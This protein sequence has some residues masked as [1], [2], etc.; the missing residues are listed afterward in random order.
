MERGRETPT[1]LV[2]RDTMLLMRRTGKQVET[3]QG[4]WKQGSVKN[5][6]DGKKRRGESRERGRELGGKNRVS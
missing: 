2:V 5:G 6:G 4:R 1:V 3:C